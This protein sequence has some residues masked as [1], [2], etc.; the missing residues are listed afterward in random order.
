VAYAGVGQ[1]GP[2][3]PAAVADPVEFL[4]AVKWRGVGVGGWSVAG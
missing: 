1:R 3:Q 4:T 2:E